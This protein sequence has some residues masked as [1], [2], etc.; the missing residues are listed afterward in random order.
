MAKLNLGAFER[1]IRVRQLR[2]DDWEPFR[3]LEESCFPGM[4]NTRVAPAGCIRHGESHCR[5]H[6]PPRRLHA[7]G[8][9]LSREPAAFAG[10]VGWHARCSPPRSSKMSAKLLRVASLEDAPVKTAIGWPA[11][12]VL[13]VTVLILLFV[14]A[15][16]LGS[17]GRSL[18]RMA[19]SE[20]ARLFQL[21]RNKAEAV[22]A[23]PGLEDQCRAEVNLMA[24]FPEC[25]D[26]CRAFVAAHKPP[27]SR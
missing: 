12:I 26:E 24:K 4:E 16:S 20:R 5:S 7:N 27:A 11:G 13:I 2:L 22:C 9:V 10:S 6:E 14:W 8:I 15:W 18:A 3:R 17:D 23:A 21:T 25:T 19:P 1:Q